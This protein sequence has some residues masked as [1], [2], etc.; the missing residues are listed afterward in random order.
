[1]NLYLRARSGYSLEVDGKFCGN[2]AGDIKLAQLGTPALIEMIPHSAGKSISFLAN[3]E[4]KNRDDIKVYALKDGFFVSANFSVCGKKGFRVL[5]QKRFGKVLCTVYRDGETRVVAETEKTAEVCVCPDGADKFEA[6]F[7]GKILFVYSVGAPSFVCAFSTEN[8][9]KKV[10]ERIFDK[11]EF[12][13]ALRTETALCDIENTV[14]ELEWKFYGG[15]MSAEEKGFKRAEFDDRI[16]SDF[17]TER[18]FFE[19]ISSGLSVDDLLTE[20][21]KSKQKYLR[22]FL[23]NFVFILPCYCSMEGVCLAYPDKDYYAVKVFSASLKNGLI[24]N[25]KEV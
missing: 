15:K 23:G 8:G 17:F 20:N 3:G 24:D 13:P 16:K 4:L 18:I 14:I 7:D 2:Y 19:R 9:L 10:M 25:I 22:D 12:T 6:R 5:Y 1:M 11:I 21:M